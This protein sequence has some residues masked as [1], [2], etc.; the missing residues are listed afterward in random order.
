MNF[1]GQPL[2]GVSASKSQ[3]LDSPDHD[4][5]FL[6]VGWVGGKRDRKNAEYIRMYQCTTQ[7]V[8]L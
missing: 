6:G 5:L 1:R 4:L 2:L 3:K 7:M 8:P